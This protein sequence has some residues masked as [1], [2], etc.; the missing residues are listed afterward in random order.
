MS[1]TVV[2]W[3]GQGRVRVCFDLGAELPVGTV[4]CHVMGGGAA[5]IFYP[6]EI[7]LFGR[8]GEEKPF[9]LSSTSEHPAETGGQ[10]S[11]A[12]MVLEPG[13][14][15]KVR[16]LEVELTPARSNCHM[17][18]DE[19]EILSPAP[20][21]KKP[22]K[23]VPDFYPA[24]LIPSSQIRFGFVYFGATSQ[25]PP[26]THM[27]KMRS[28]GFNAVHSECNTAYGNT[29]WKDLNPEKGVFCWAPLDKW[30]AGA[31]AAGLSVP[32]MT[33]IEGG[34]PPWILREFPDAEFVNPYG[35]T[36]PGLID[37][38]HPGVL[39]ALAEYLSAMAG[40]YRDSGFIAGYIIG[41]EYSVYQNY[42]HK[43]NFYAQNFNSRMKA[44]FQE[45]LREKYVSVEALNRRFGSRYTDFASVTPSLKWITGRENEHEWA[46]WC[47]FR[48]L[49]AARIYKAMRDAIHKA[50]PSKKIVLSA[51]AAVWPYHSVSGIHLADFPWLD[52]FGEKLM[53][54]DTPESV[55]DCGIHGRLMRGV[56]NRNKKLWVTNL[57]YHGLPNS[58]SGH[59][60]GLFELM[61]TGVDLA[62]YFL[63]DIHGGKDRWIKD[64]PCFFSL[65]KDKNYAS[66]AELDILARLTPFLGRYGDWIAQAEP[67]FSQLGILLPFESYHHE[68]RNNLTEAYLQKNR[69]P[70]HPN[71]S[72]PS[73]VAM[74]AVARFANK[75]NIAFEGANIDRLEGF[76]AVSVTGNANL[77]DHAIG[78]LADFV[79]KGGLLIADAECGKYDEL[80][81][82]R[83]KPFADFFPAHKERILF[84]EPRQ[85]H[86]ETSR[87]KSFLNFRKTVSVTDGGV[88][89]LTSGKSAVVLL[90]NRGAFSS[91]LSSVDLRISGD[92]LPP[93]PFRVY[94]V[95]PGTS[96]H[97]EIP[98]RR[99][100]KDLL[101]SNLAFKDAFAL[102]IVNGSLET[103]SALLPE[104]KRSVGGIPPGSSGFLSSSVPR[105]TAMRFRW[106]WT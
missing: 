11:S 34:I 69:Y 99:E 91:R 6:A 45:Y 98:F 83:T 81:L 72:E 80:G 90:T 27:L 30:V 65:D 48:E 92:V 46:E 14:V 76:K 66:S 28:L 56:G 87:L 57:S 10:A 39:N 44:A 104:Y 63:W 36:V 13:D 53:I 37:F 38:G 43:K 89:L 1:G 100:G 64:A 18:A 47:R 79:R 103:G 85:I 67:A 5:G 55:A 70:K 105:R 51:V 71:L 12:W 78:R 33:G 52:V 94:G 32:V 77:S 75:E 24:N 74:M 35:E 96:P 82:K 2:G 54:R 106:S 60:R 58:E 17:M 88:S 61:G 19:I 42:Y 95:E 3:L 93:E 26:E 21:E 25:W 9:L 62:T 20:A 7:R 101:I 84:I 102:L 22:G 40:R 4:K 23:T 41:D 15:R 16:Y 73:Y 97:R 68:F 8:S 50:D 59:T 29:R 86:A 31:S 49:E